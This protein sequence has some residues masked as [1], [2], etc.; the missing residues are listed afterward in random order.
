VDSFEK[1]QLRPG[2]ILLFHEDYRLTVEALPRILDRLM[3][4][5]YNFVSV[6]ELNA[7]TAG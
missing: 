4:E 6:S 2:D 3:A 1:Q 5:K 7:A